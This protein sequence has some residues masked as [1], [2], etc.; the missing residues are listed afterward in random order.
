MKW[1]H[2]QTTTTSKT[3]DQLRL[4]IRNGAWFRERKLDVV[5]S[6]KEELLNICDEIIVDECIKEEVERI[7]TPQKQKEFGVPVHYLLNIHNFED[8]DKVINI[9]IKSLKLNN[10]MLRDVYTIFDL[11]VPSLYDRITFSD[12]SKLFNINQGGVVVIKADMDIANDDV[13]SI[14]KELIN[15]FTSQIKHNSTEVTTILCCVGKNKSLAID[16]QNK[17]TDLLFVEIND[18]TLSNERAKKYLLNHA[19][20]LNI[21]D[22]SGLT[23]MIVTDIS[24]KPNDLLTIFR[25]WHKSYVKTIQFPQYSQFV[26]QLIGSFVT[27]SLFINIVFSLHFIHLSLDSQYSQFVEHSSHCLVSEL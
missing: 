17:L 12:V 19:K 11:T 20:H 10:R 18:T 5:T 27:H 16:F 8:C 14:E 1:K 24:Y 4:N 21:A 23:D 9:L 15:I 13:F 7:F 3:A 26:G 22:M 6:K 2:R 25:K